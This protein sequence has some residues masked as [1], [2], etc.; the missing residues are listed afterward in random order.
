MIKIKRLLG[1]NPI[2]FPL[3][4]VPTYRVIEL[5]YESQ[6]YGERSGI[7]PMI[8]DCSPGG[9]GTSTGIVVGVASRNT[10]DDLDY[11]ICADYPQL[12]VDLSNGGSLQFVEMSS[13]CTKSFQIILKLTFLFQH[14]TCSPKRIPS[15]RLWRLRCTPRNNTSTGRAFFDIKFGKF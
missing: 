11:M 5:R 13:V 1:L 6:D 2:Y 4:L 8:M 3:I 9:D 14:L 10:I 12:F 7:P 15:S